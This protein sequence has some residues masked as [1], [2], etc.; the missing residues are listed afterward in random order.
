MTAQ[1]F[2]KIKIVLLTVRQ[3]GVAHYPQNERPMKKTM[4]AC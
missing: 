4:G 3:E 2:K 1:I